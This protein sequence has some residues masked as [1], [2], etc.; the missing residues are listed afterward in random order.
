MKKADLLKIE[1]M[2]EEMADKVIEGFS[3][4]I[5][6]SRFDEVNEAKKTL[7]TQIETLKKSASASDDL[8]KQ[9]EA[10]Q[11][12][13]R[14]S[15]EQVKKA[16]IDGAVNLALKDAGAKNVKAVLP[17]LKE[18]SEIDDNGV[19]KG[20]SD[21]IEELKKGESTSFLFGTKEVTKPNPK[22]STPANKGTDPKGG[23]VTKEQFNKMGYKA[24]LDLYNN[25]KELYDQL[26]KESE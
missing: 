2:T 1:G 11:E 20:L 6:K 25:D 18:L 17:F 4:Y 22:G 24:R 3:G 14:K 21:Q 26:S 5:P 16:K 13:N 7:E 15:Q 23:T 8:K 10:L 12:E 19:V 9:I